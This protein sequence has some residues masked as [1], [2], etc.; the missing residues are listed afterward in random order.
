[1]KKITF[2]FGSALLL[3][4]PVH[5]E[6]G[7]NTADRGSQLYENHCTGCH[8]SQVHIREKR[9]A[10]TLTEVQGFVRRWADVQALGWT[11]EEIREVLAYLNATYY[12]YP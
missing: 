7:G 6:T 2:L 9:K 10:R 12:K 8:E 4:P 5:A 3:M 1:M 11:D